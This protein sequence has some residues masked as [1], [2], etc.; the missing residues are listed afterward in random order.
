M[1]PFL[2]ILAAL[3]A[4]V[5]RVD[6]AAAQQPA[7]ADTSRPMVLVP[8]AVWNGVADAPARGWVVVLRGA[9]I[10]AA[11]PAEKVEVPA[12][13]ERVE[14]AGTTLIPGLIE[15]HSHLFCTRTMKRSG[16]TRS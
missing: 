12:G 7:G 16:T 14:L 10:A 4:V 6:P 3:A 11:G 15:G 2:R 5:L 1:R 8:G 13:A 9:R